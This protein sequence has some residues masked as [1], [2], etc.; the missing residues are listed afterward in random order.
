[1]YN[2]RLQDVSINKYRQGRCEN[3]RVIMEKV[4]KIHKTLWCVL[5]LNKCGGN[6]VGWVDSEGV[7]EIVDLSGDK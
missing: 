3:K 7:F 6:I 1:M 5:N 2:N 4:N